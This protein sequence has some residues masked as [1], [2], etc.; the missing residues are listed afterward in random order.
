LAKGDFKFTLRGRHLRGSWV[1]VRIKAWSGTKVNWLLIKHRDAFAVEGDGDALLLAD[2]SVASGRTMAAIAA[3]TGR[4]P[5][6]FMV[7]T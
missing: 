6:P 7:K 3:G 4:K 1:L 5:R 2:R